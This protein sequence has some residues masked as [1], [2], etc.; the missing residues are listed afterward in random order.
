MKNYF[1]YIFILNLSIFNAQEYRW[2]GDFDNDFFNELNWI[3]TTTESSPSIGS[4]NPGEPINFKLFLTCI[5]EANDEIIIDDNGVI[6]LLHGELN[7]EKISGTGKIILNEASY[8]NLNDEYPISEGINISINSHKSWVRLY[9]VEPSNA[10]YYYSDNFF[11]ED[12]QLS[13]PENIRFD[14]YYAKGSVI[15][16]NQIQFSNLTIFSE[17]NYDGEF[18][19]VNNNNVFS[20]E[21]IP[22]NLEDNISSFKLNKGH[23]VTFSENE[24]GSGNSKVFIA[25]ESDLFVKELPFNL[26]N[27]ISFIRVI[28]WNWVNKKG[29]AGDIL[30][31]NN[32]WFYMWS[33]NGN[34]DIDREYTPMAWGSGAA[35]DDNDIEIFKSKYKSTHLLAFNE[36][37][38][39]NGQSGQFNNMCDVDVALSYYK[40][41]LNT[42]LRMVSPAC[43]QGAAFSWLLEFKLKAT[44]QKM[45]IDAI[46]VHWYDW[47]SSPQATPNANPQDVFNRFKNYLSAVYN[48]YGL[49]IWITEF[50][51]NRYRNEWVHR[52]FLEL[53]L[54]YL[55]ETEYIE[56]YSFFP[57]QTG[58]ADFFDS[59]NNFNP[60]GELYYNFDSSETIIED[61][62]YSDSNLDADDYENDYEFICD[63]EDI[64]LS[65]QDLNLNSRIKIYPNPSSNY[66]F[67]DYDFQIEKLK[68]LDLKGLN[69]K[70]INPTKIIDISFLENGIYILN[71]ND[72]YIKFIKN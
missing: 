36:P 58:V 21:S 61:Y 17:N 43:R 60:I 54:P 71:V 32:N 33:N 38:D 56:R 34:S 18:A 14:N 20:G 23:M 9:N 59:N 26:N 31:M 72:N 67:I 62:Y 42:G 63:A 27:K 40:N 24:D 8:I 25:S 65:N 57:P 10:F 70:K 3:E 15:R 48:M 29:T 5:A 4:I 66:I 49:P 11:Y 16:L 37:D 45:R 22:N 64:F 46:A 41:L 2:S 55:E 19:F 53:A 35:D 28:P 50:N 12:Q 47:D 68:I 13:Y 30:S 7:A 1:V 69:L 39:C 6:D 52:Q 44:K 51:A